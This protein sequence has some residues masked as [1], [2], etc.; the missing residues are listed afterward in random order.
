MLWQFSVSF[1]ALSII[2]D[3]AF[4][5]PVPQLA[6][7]LRPLPP[8]LPLL[9]P[10]PEVH[11]PAAF[12]AGVSLVRPTTFHLRTSRLCLPG[13]GRVPARF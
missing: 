2:I 10:L 11:L 1:A 3:V 12:L 6:V 13:I 9:I 7:H 5:Y 4:T 8:L